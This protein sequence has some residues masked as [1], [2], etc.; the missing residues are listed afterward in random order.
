MGLR[1][2]IGLADQAVGATFELGLAGRALKVGLQVELEPA[3]P[4]HRADLAIYRGAR[5]SETLYVEA[6]HI[7]AFPK[8]AYDVDQLFHW[9]FPI[10][11]WGLRCGGQFF[12][13]PLPEEMPLL[14]Q[15]VDAFWGERRKTRTRGDLVIEGMLQLWAAHRDVHEAEE[16]YVSRSFPPAGSRTSP[17]VTFDVF[18]RITNA[19]HGK[20]QQLPQDHGGMIALETPVEPELLQVPSEALAEARETAVRDLPSIIAVALVHRSPSPGPPTH[21]VRDLGRRHVSVRA[22]RFLIFSE[23]VILVR[24]PRRIHS[25]AGGIVEC[26]FTS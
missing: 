17:P 6:K 5:S 7:Q 26:L 2:R 14:I 21:K 13:T 4:G 24:N 9:V 3:I 1:S 22:P 11:P 16:Y 12:R 18:E 20:S 15:R 10:F 8:R 19:I 23:E 25:A